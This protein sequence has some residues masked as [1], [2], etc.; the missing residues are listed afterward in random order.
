MGTARKRRTGAHRAFYDI[1]VDFLG[2]VRWEKRVRA[3]YIDRAMLEHVLAALMPENRLALEVS[4]HTGLR[5]GDVLALKTAELRQRMSVREEKTGKRRRI[6]LPVE[7]LDRLVAQAGKIY[8]FEGRTD[9]RKH[10]TRQAVWKDLRRAAEAFRLV[11]HVSPHSA[12]KLYAVEQ[13]QESGGDLGAVQRR[14]LHSDPAV[15]AIYAMAD[16]LTARRLQGR[17]RRTR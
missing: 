7:L 14:L 16:A 13:Y 4:A 10:R 3:E 5:I 15:T 9:Y 12:R 2:K 1:A 17:K 6:Y 11:E 8:V